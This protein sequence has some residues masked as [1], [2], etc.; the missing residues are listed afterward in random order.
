[1]QGTNVKISDVIVY[2]YLLCQY[3]SYTM[4]STPIELCLL[5]SITENTQVTEGCNYFRRRPHVG[6]PWLKETGWVG[7][8]GKT[9]GVT[10]VGFCEDD[11]IR[12]D[13]IKGI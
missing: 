11:H 5:N 1:M 4:F 3:I 6:R 2:K 10:M 8:S 7:S 12:P 9:Q 13:W